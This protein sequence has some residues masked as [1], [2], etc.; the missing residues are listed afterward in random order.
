MEERE[1][2]MIEERGE[3]EEMSK[4]SEGKGRERRRGERKKRGH[5]TNLSFY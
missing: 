1:W 2:E 5:V 4:V 3:E